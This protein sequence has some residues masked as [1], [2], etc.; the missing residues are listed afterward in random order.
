MCGVMCE[1]GFGGIGEW[2]GFFERFLLSMRL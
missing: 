2:W 1:W